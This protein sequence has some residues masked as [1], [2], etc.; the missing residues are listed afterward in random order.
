MAIVGVSRVIPRFRQY[1][2]G[3]DVEKS[4][5]GL[6]ALDVRSG[7]ILAEIYWPSGNQIFAIEALP[8]G[9]G[10]LPFLPGGTNVPE[11]FYAFSTINQK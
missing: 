1:A 2:P 10:H 7:Q 11:L 5:C 4:R 6:L 8:L 3:L 9:A